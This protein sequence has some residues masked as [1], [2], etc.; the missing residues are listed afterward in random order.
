MSRI[1]EKG[2]IYERKREEEKEKR[3]MTHLIFQCVL[4]ETYNFI[5]KYG[6]RK[7]PENSEWSTSFIHILVFADEN[8]VQN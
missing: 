5:Y 8:V 1:K 6:Q 4:M 3:A 7:F 2:G